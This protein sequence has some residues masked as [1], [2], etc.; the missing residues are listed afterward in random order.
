MHAI[1]LQDANSL[2]VKPDQLIRILR[3]LRSRFPW[4][5]RITSYARSHTI[6]RISD[7]NLRQMRE[8]GLNRI[9]I[10]LES[11]SD[12][13]LDR[14]RKGV[15]K[16]TQ[17][18]AGQKVKKA[19]MEL[20]EYV[21]PGLG[22]KALSRDHALETADALNRINPDFIRLRTLALPGGIPLADEHRSGRCNAKP[23]RRPGWPASVP[24]VNG[25]CYLPPSLTTGTVPPVGRG[26]RAWP[27][28][29]TTRWVSSSAM[30]TSSPSLS[31]RTP[32]SSLEAL[33]WPTD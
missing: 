26:P 20:S 17:I 5:D 14:V 28:K 30:R 23:V 4:V 19:G 24:P 12:A 13:V 31:H 18:K 10:G 15:D 2:I 33:P 3:H 7:G 21:M 8:A 22:G 27:T 9:H 25:A 32:R 16:R 1:F 11:G 29:S 6:A